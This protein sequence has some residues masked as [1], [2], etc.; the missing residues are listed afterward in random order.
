M[1][2]FLLKL[3]NSSA[4]I[5]DLGVVIRYKGS[6]NPQSKPLLSTQT[7]IDITDG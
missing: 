6:F 7:P 4:G 5:G 1:G 2:F 3:A